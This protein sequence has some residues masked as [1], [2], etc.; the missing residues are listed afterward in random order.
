MDPKRYLPP[1]YWFCRTSA[2]TSLA[3]SNS[4]SSSWLHIRLTACLPVVWCSSTHPAASLDS[5]LD[6]N[7][8]F[9]I[10]EASQGR[11]G[12]N[13][14]VERKKQEGRKERRRDE[15]RE[16]TTH[17]VMRLGGSERGRSRSL[18]P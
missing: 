6:P 14:E 4:S 11:R 8:N 7:P 13:T 2:H 3:P 12:A 18:T 5:H 10:K 1:S 17:R 15:E 16:K 9:P